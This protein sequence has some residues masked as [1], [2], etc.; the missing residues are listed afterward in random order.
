MSILKNGVSTAA[1]QFPLFNVN[2]TLVLL[3]RVPLASNQ[4]S[5]SA[6]LPLNAGDT[7]SLAI[8]N[9]A[10]MNQAFRGTLKI[11]PLP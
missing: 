7:I 8:S 1:V 3:L 11:T 5:E 4:V 9:G 10:T 2:I 6:V